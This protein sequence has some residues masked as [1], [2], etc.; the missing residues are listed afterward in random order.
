M[1]Q[2]SFDPGPVAG[3]AWP[4]SV[5]PGEPFDLC[6][7]NRLA[8][9][10]VTIEIARIGAERE[11][12]WSGSAE[13]ADHPYPEGFTG[14]GC[15]WPAAV[16][17]TAGVDW[18][19]GYYE[20]LM[21]GEEGP[22]SRAFVVVRAAPGAEADILLPLST[23][24][25]NAYN[26]VHNGLSLYTGA[27]VVAFTRPMSPG[28]LYKPEGIGMRV[29]PEHVPDTLRVAYTGY[30]VQHGFSDWCG[31]AGWP[32]WEYPFAVW[33][34]REGYRVD[35]ATNADLERGPEF[36]APY[37]LVVSVGHDEYWS[38]PMR[39]AVE[40]YIEAGGNVAFLSGNTAFWQVRI[41]QS[42]TAM[43]AY[44]Y[45]FE[46]DPV[47][48]TEREGELT[49]IWSDRAIG[50]PENEMTGVSFCRGGYARIAAR[51]PEGS[52]A[53]TIHRADHWLLE[54]TG[55]VFGDLLGA[56]SVIVGFEADGCEIAYRDGLP[57]PTG[58]DGTP[59]DFEIV[60]TSPVEPLDR[61][62]GPRPIPDEQ[63][64]EMEFIAWRVFGDADPANQARIAHGHCVMGTFTRGAGTVVTVGCTEWANGLRGRSPRVEQVTRNIITR[65]L[66]TDPEALSR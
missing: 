27:N 7:T 49:S 21:R 11:V 23:N 66:D 12:V 64:S 55:L 20:I 30:K 65:A 1:P 44:K 50:R 53:Y 29:I 42:G 56:E 41:E 25:W 60:A 5:T 57:Y 43:V 4:Q 3:Y 52:G 46:R 47:Y 54:G 22:A 2:M 10:A 63:P 48:G 18:R 17:V 16:S 13:V 39:D 28:F 45:D 24:T 38:R 37:R 33:A 19:S 51:V 31:A 15:D 59:T 14:A 58:S 9:S 32:G 34:E 61:Y 6:L 36:L 40:S 62:S 35:Y 26:D 8:A